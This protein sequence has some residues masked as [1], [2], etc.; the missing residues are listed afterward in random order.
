MQRSFIKGAALCL[1]NSAT[2]A[3]SELPASQPRL[4][5]VLVTAQRREQSIDD[6]PLV[7]SAWDGEALDRLGVIDTRDLG[8]LLPGFSYADGGFNTPIYTLRGVGFNE[9]SQTASA[10]VGVYFDE[11]NLPFP[12]MSKGPTVDLER[13]EVLKGPQGT[14]YGRNTTGGAINFISNKP[15]E[16]FSYGIQANVS[17][18]ETQDIEAMVSGPLLDGLNAR[19]A[20][21]SIESKEGWQQSHTRHEDSVA[22]NG[23]TGRDLGG[24]YGRFGNDELGEQDKLAGRLLLEWLAS[25]DVEVNL[26][27]QYWYDRSEPQ[28]LQV[29][30]LDRR[31]TTQGDPPLHP[32]VANYPV[33]NFDNRDNR[34]ADWVNDGTEFRLN[35]DFE[36]LGLR[37]NWALGDV[38]DVAVL[39]SSGR[40]ESDGSFIPQSGVDT[41]NTER[42]VFA[43]TEFKSLELRLS[44]RRADW[45]WQVGGNI[46]EDDVQEFQRL[47]HETVS[48]VFPVD[49]PD[50]DG[51][52]GLDNRSGFGGN[53]TA[54]V[55]AVFF[56]SEWQFLPAW[57]LTLAA[58][59]TDEVR[60]FDGCSQDVDVETEPGADQEPPGAQ[61]EGI[62][63]AQAFTGI[64]A[65]QS[66]AAGFTPG[67]AQPGG[68]FT[69]DAETRRPQRFFGE[70]AEDNISGRIALD[71][72]PSDQA[73]VFLAYSRGYKSGSFPLINISDSV[74]YTPATQ[75]RLDAI[76][77]GAKLQWFDERLKL[78]VSAF[79][80][81]YQDK[82]L[83]TNFRDPVFGPL[84]ILRNAPESRVRG[85]ELELNWRPAQALT[86]NLA[87]AYLDSEVERFVSGNLE[88]ESFDFA[89]RPFNYTSPW[90]GT[91]GVNWQHRWSNLM[92]NMGLEYR[93]TGA[94]NASLE[95][96]PRFE[97]EAYHLLNARIGIAAVDGPWSFQF[98]S[99]NLTDEYYYNNVT[100]QIDTVGRY[101]GMP[102]T[103][104][105][106]VS[107]Y[108][109]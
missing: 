61:N 76:E 55:W 54:D 99:R 18:F 7:I 73:L 80:Y 102:R 74:Q 53:Q 109:F 42:N 36:A 9:N 89:G 107:W 27:Y 91:A 96:D 90:E 51:V 81:D 25:D 45:F 63:L 29:I 56:H 44:Q 24:Q 14:L 38:T 31:D 39:V 22:Y 85:G 83:V 97:I 78:N 72:S 34:S 1:L 101:T 64:S 48:I 21:R 50:G 100:N 77:V 20:L 93:Y 30:G 6:I 8:I 19:L 69:L 103:V 59:Y 105:M 33:H 52:A 86:V 4:E 87:A 26:Q 46:T 47:H 28:A 71:W 35:D 88:G 11:F 37:V 62:G 65:T 94:S 66:P 95:G 10:T 5:T 40:F 67:V 43:E 3:Q 17:S 58:R 68:C 75:E 104:G 57:Q 92:F 41:S 16:T 108:R 79:N 2:W 32:D 106:S 13:V 82:Q 60:E 84:P 49:A 98:W 23:R 15:T 12:I 70:L